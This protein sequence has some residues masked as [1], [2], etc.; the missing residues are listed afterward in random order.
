[1]KVSVVVPLVGSAGRSAVERLQRCVESLL[2]QSMPPQDYEFL[3]VAPAGMN[4]PPAH[5]PRLSGDGSRVRIHQVSDASDAGA[6][7]NAGLALA[8]GEYVLF[9]DPGTELGREALARMHALAVRNGSDVVL[10]KASGPLPGYDGLFRRTLE[11][12]DV[13]DAPLFDALDAGHLFRRSFLMDAEIRF[14]E[15]HPLADQLVM[16][17][18]YLTAKTVTVL[19]DYPCYVR[20]PG[21]G[22]P[23]GSDAWAERPLAYV[24]GLRDLLDTLVAG[25]EPGDLRDRLLGWVLRTEILDRLSEPGLLSLPEPRREEFFHAVRALAADHIPARLHPGLSP[26]HRLRAALLERGRLDALVEFARRCRGIK[27]QARLAGLRWEDGRLCADVRLEIVHTDGSPVV[28]VERDGRFHLD[29]ALVAELPGGP[30]DEGD[31]WEVGDPL[32][33]TAAEAMVRDRDADVWWPV[34]ARLLASVEPVDGTPVDAAPIDAARE[35]RLRVVLAGTLAFDPRTLAC[36]APVGR[37]VYDVSVS[38]T[39]LGFTRRPRLGGDRTPTTQ[40][41]PAIVGGRAVFVQPYWSRPGGHL[42][43]DVEERFR[44]LGRELATRGVGSARG[45]DGRVRLLLPVVAGPD[46]AVRDVE[47]MLGRGPAASRVPARI[48]P[49]VDGVLLSFGDGIGLPNGHYPL[50]LHIDPSD[51]RP[52][53][54][55]ATA[56]VRSGRIARVRGTP[57]AQTPRRGIARLRGSWMPRQTLQ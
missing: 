41:S 40:A 53:V 50:T 47:V 52:A 30:V 28:V 35:R 25:T 42:S 38:M 24:T 22:E 51:Q 55:I 34:P 17:Q 26:T 12:C 5:L 11:R 7:R 36:G 6:L 13:E 14:V 45:R 20:A 21:D 31:V 57:Y 10:G 8:G 2:R 16:A 39:A 27:S 33:G 32:A 23:A 49:G 54:P 9:V 1:M 18:A 46:A 43:L 19:S 37:G 29:P 48:E 4:A 44:T 56:T 3:V 15:G